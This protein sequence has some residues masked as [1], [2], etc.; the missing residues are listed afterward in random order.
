MNSIIVKPVSK[1]YCVNTNSVGAII[2][3]FMATSRDL[4][5]MTGFWLGE[6]LHSLV[7]ARTTEAIFW[8]G[9]LISLFIMSWLTQRFDT[10]GWLLFSS[11]FYT[12]FAF[13]VLSVALGLRCHWL[14]LE[15]ARW[16]IV[17]FLASLLW[18]LLQ[19]V[20]P[21]NYQAIAGGLGAE[22]SP[23]WF[24]PFSVLSVAPEKTRWLLL[25]NSL[26]FSWFLM[27][28][29]LLDSRR[30][31]KQFL[32]VLLLIG[33]LHAFVG[34]FAMYADIY[35]V[36][37]TQL[38][39]HFKLARGW[40][41]NRNHFAAFLNLTLVASFTVLIRRLLQTQE[42]PTFNNILDLLVS[43]KVLYLAIVILV[44]VAIS[45][46]Q[47]RG[48]LASVILS[49][50][51]MWTIARWV[52]PAAIRLSWWYIWPS[53]LL[54]LLLLVN[55]G[56]N[57]LLRL[58]T[59]FFSLGERSTQW[60]ITWQAISQSPWFGYGGGSYGTVFQVFRGY[61]ELRDVVYNQ[62][63]NEYLHLW[64]EQGLVGLTLWL[65]M[66]LLTIWHG[67]SAF[68]NTKSTLIS[69]VLMA[70]QIAII[71]ALLQ[72]GVDFNLQIIN[73]RCYFFTIAAL[74]FSVPYIR[75]NGGLRLGRASA[76]A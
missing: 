68:R 72:A 11:A 48:G 45:L 66:V 18:L 61:V 12:F 29:A 56:E 31:I 50:L 32:T 49:L 53:L 3:T 47:S 33:S 40:F 62:S 15:K 43:P 13:F 8:W 41:V 16:L 21:D 64:L 28:L 6:K 46:S 23:E 30:R 63:H 73:I 1:K 20:I 58:T 14:A 52:K 35:L 22:A 19:I 9:Y 10:K 71:A 44:F 76:R 57:L 25:S 70:S 38:D 65:G 59:D 5:R 39:G 60:S 54:V 34:I 24:S 26:V 27:S 74:I 36:D 51:F 75:Q 37:R 2:S 4:S 69:A 17:C 42:S 55:F 67:L 7:K